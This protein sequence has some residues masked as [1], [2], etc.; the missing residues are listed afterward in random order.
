MKALMETLRKE[1]AVG[2]P[3]WELK[4]HLFT[5]GTQIWGGILKNSH[6]KVFEKGMK[7]HMTSHVKVHPSTKV[8]GA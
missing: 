7:M 1:A 8:E 4:S 2:I 3:C 6:W 5:Y